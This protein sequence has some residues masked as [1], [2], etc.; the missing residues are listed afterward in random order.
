MSAQRAN[1]V[2]VSTIPPAMDKP[3]R[4]ALADSV[5]KRL[6][7]MCSQIGAVLMSHEHNFR[8]VDNPHKGD[9]RKNG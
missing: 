7:D 9:F 8:Y 4:Q 6:P 2:I 3:D 1:N 5:N